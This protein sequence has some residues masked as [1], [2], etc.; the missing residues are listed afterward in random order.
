MP[1][2]KGNKLGV[3]SIGDQPMTGRIDIRTSK[4]LEERVKAIPNW[5]EKLRELL[6]GWGKNQESSNLS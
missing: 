6:E 3:K 2:K 5:R 1:F 4:E